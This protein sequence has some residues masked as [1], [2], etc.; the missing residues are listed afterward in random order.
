MTDL[1][2]TKQGA[3]GRATLNRPKALNAITHQML[4]DLE[5]AMQDWVAEDNVKL[6]LVDAV[7]D[8]AFCAGGDIVDLYNE[9]VQG[10]DEMARTFWRDEYRINAAIESYTK[11]YIAIMD[12]IV[13]GGGVGI[14]AHGS[15]RIVTERTMFA[16]PECAIGIIPDVGGSLLLA[17]MPGHCGEYA[18][19][20]GARLSGAD[21]IYTGLADFYVESDRLEDLKAALCE[22]GDPEIIRQYASVPP[23]SDLEINI[24][25]IN[26]LFNGDTVAD[27]QTTLQNASSDFAIAAAKGLSRGAPLGLM[28]ALKTIRAARVDNDMALA[29]RN[30]YRF[31]TNA[32][33]SGE[34]IEGVRAAVIDKDRKPAWKYP[35]LDSVPVELIDAL[36]HPAPNGDF[37]A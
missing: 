12:G 25:T 33:N 3:A 2:V 13:M 21:C 37:I 28:S 11:P 15:H 24:D 22:T 32:V 16:M 6:A 30:E 17:R 14:S 5:I 4:L 27:I 29:L 18:G 10:R 7:G 31:V 34:F 23:T 8:R 1:I 19:L 35:T 20:T 36:D 9:G 26:T